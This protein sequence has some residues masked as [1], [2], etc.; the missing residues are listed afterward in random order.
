MEERKVRALYNFESEYQ[1]PDRQ[2]CDFFVFFLLARIS[3]L[4]SL[5]VSYTAF[6][7]LDFGV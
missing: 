2:T 1:L 5:S 7:V 3:R 6:D 4:D